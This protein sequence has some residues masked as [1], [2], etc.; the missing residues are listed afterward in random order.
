[1]WVEEGTLAR[2]PLSGGEP[3][4]VVADVEW[5]DWSADGRR[6]AIVRHSEGRDRLEFPVGTAEPDFHR[7]VVEMATGIPDADPELEAEPSF[8]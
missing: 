2:V 4:E 3:R 7:W 5:A 6:L 8:D 1:M